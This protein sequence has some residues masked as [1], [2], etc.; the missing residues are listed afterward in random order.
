MKPTNQQTRI[1]KDFKDTRVMKINAVAGSGKTSTLKLLAEEYPQ[2]SLYMAFNK[3]IATEA[4]QEFPDYV[5]C[6]TTHSLAFAGFGRALM[7]KLKRPPYKKN[8]AQS[9]TEIASYYKLEDIGEIK[10]SILGLMVKLTVTKF[11]QSADKRI[12]TQ[13]IP[14][15]VM[16]DLKK[17][18]EEIDEQEV[19][20]VVLATAKK[21]W[22]EKKDPSSSVLAA[23]DTY[24]KLWQ[25]SKP[26]LNFDIIYIDEAQDIN[27]VVLDVA[28]NQTHAKIVYVGDTYQSIYQFRGAINAMESVVAPARLLSMSF[29]YGQPIADVA[30]GII[31]GAVDIQG[32]PDIE[33]EVAPVDTSKKYTKLFRTNGKLL[34]EAVE[35]LEEGYKVKCEIDVWDFVNTLTSA[36]ALRKGKMNQVKHETIIPYTSWDDLVEC[37]EEDPELKRVKHIVTKGLVSRYVKQLTDLAH[38]K[39][40]FYDILLTTAHKSKGRQWDQVVLADDYPDIESFK[41]ISDQERNLIYVAA[42][43]AVKTLELPINILMALQP[44]EEAA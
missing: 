30:K 2:N 33:S 39:S 44:I 34:Q 7:H 31:G 29:R 32:N 9:S 43:R 15:Q 17:T 6:R 10:A 41:E 24:L 20:K 36:D 13:H 38:S 35:L 11:E 16:Y 18:H 26:R 5:E 42:T 21:H 40:K 12:D 14:R 27:P 37:S 4:A 8:V 1:I 3:A 25:L 22:N 23:H 28:E 19:K